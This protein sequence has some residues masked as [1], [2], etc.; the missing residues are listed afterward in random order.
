MIGLLIPY[1][2]LKLGR[3]VAGALPSKLL[4]F[5]A[6]VIIGIEAG[7]LAA[8]LLSV[9]SN[10]QS[11]GPVRYGYV[12]ADGHGFAILPS[13]KLVREDFCAYS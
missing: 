5:A 2:E 7:S 12:T 3:F 1:S 10:G 11:S 9:R 4:H 8:A 6:D 13:C